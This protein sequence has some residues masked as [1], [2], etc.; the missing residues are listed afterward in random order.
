MGTERERERNEMKWTE[1]IKCDNV[2][3][4]TNI[5]KERKRG[6][7]RSERV[8]NRVIKESD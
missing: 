6:R 2:K 8:K 3:S 5:G 4:V 7:E 1:K